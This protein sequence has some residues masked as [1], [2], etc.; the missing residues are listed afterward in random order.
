MR[1][2]E[3]DQRKLKE[4]LIRNVHIDSIDE[5]G[6]YIV[7]GGING[8]VHYLHPDGIIRIGINNDGVGAFWPNEQS[9]TVFFVAWKV[10]DDD[11]WDGLGMT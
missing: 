11:F 2:D 1:Y 8:G 7:A 5:R 9:A 3:K 10:A 6:W 4:F